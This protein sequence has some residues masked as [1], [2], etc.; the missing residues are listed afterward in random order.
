MNEIDP[1]EATKIEHDQLREELERAS[2]VGGETAEA[3]Q[4]VLAVLSPHMLLEEDLAIPPLK[5]LPRLARGEFTSDMESV[6]STT[7][8]LK[9]ELPRMLGEHALLVAALRRLLQA[10]VRER[11]DGYAAFAQKLILHAQQEEEVYYPASILVGEYVKL[12]L[13][14]R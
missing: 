6:L 9:A 13:G 10:A 7:E 14:Q 4:A 12:R 8:T 1:P 3:A 5:L 11:H 2:A